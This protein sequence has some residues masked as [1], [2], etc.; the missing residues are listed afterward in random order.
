MGSISS[1]RFSPDGHFLVF[2][3]SPVLGVPGN[4]ES[5]QEYVSRAGSLAAASSNGLPM[6]VWT[7]ELPDDEPRPLAPLQLD[8]PG[9]AWSGDGKRI[10]VLAGAGIFVIDAEDGAS[11]RLGEGTFHGQ[12]AWL[13]D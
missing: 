1:P 4:I 11:Q 13:S 2:A 9:L 8:Q 6:D 7:M 3:A 10:F 12:L 5:D